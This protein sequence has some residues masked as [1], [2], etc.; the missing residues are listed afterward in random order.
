MPA[1]IR[2][3]VFAEDEVV[4]ALRDYYRRSGQK[5]PDRTVLHLTIVSDLPPTIKLTTRATRSRSRSEFS[6]TGEELLSALIFY[7]HNQQIPLPVRGSKDVT[8]LNDRLTIV[9]KLP[10][11]SARARAA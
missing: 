2:H 5:L 11:Q 9:V 4:A 3:L 10:R 1:E 6:V 7:C 8:I